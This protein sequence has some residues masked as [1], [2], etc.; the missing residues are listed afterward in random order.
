LLPQ[1][2]DRI[3]SSAVSSSTN[4]L[5]EDQLANRDVLTRFRK[6]LQIEIDLIEKK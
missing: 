5:K 1:G 3:L 2:G 4:Q 6:A